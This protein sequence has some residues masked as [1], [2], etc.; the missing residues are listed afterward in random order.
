MYK[1]E[2]HKKTWI[3][4]SL[5]CANLLHLEDAVKELNE[6][7]ID[8]IH[9]DVVDGK[10]NNCFAFGDIILERIRPLCTKPI[11]V[12][13]AVEDVRPYIEPFAKAGADYIAV[14][15][16]IQDDLQ[17]IFQLIKKAGARPILAFRC[18]SEVPED[19]TEL[20]KQ[21]DWILKLTVEPGYAGQCMQ[22]QA[23][24]HIQ[25]MKEM[26][27]KHQISTRIQADGNICEKT[28]PI[29]SKAGADILTG[30]TSGLFI[31]DS[32]LQE[33]LQ[34]MKEAAI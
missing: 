16:E 25:I 7:T 29:V 14:H 31:K 33:S 26:L 10:F 30:G 17:E 23:I 13:L 34:R 15:Y 11:E 19:F 2:N 22:P 3:S 8:F 24:E 1:I 21:V 4:A 18:D 6:S 20:A 32:N 12:H 28:I 5:S 27:L 9:Y